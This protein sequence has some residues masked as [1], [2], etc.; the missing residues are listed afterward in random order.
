[1]LPA[2]ETS[3]K[4]GL[5]MLHTRRTQVRKEIAEQEEA[6]KMEDQQQITAS[7]SSSSSV[8]WEQS[9]LNTILNAAEVSFIQN[10]LSRIDEN[11]VVLDKFAI[12]MTIEKLKCLRPNVWLNDEVINFYFN[13]LKAQNSTIHC[14]ST[15]FFVKLCPGNLSKFSFDNVRR[16]TKS[17]D[18]FSKRKI[19]IPIHHN[20]NH[21]VLIFIDIV[22]KEVHFMD[23]YHKEKLVYTNITL[24]VYAFD[25]WRFV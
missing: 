12:P 14:F 10:L 21:W 4:Q 17:V 25:S 18:I 2:N 3:N 15:H 11:H 19:F 5:E 23:S 7:T 20:K 9:L 6:K 13:M 22:K 16:W 1:M 24:E 8:A